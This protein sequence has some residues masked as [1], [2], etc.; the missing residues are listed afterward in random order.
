MDMH[1]DPEF[2]ALIRDFVSDLAGKLDTITRARTAADREALA[3]EAHRI[4]GS[5]GA[6]GFERLGA[7]ARACEQQVR[8]GGDD[9]AVDRAADALEA[10][11][12]AAAS[13][14]SNAA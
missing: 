3:T 1:D 2:Q 8:G 13:S 5:A 4:A 10:E 12:R 14:R 11:I 7:T 9:G 6:Y